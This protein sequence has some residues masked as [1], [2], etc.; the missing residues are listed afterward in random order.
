MLPKQDIQ[1]KKI[2]LRDYAQAVLRRK[3]IVIVSF[4]TLVTTVTIFSFKATPIYQATTQVMINKENP[5]VVSFKEVMSLDIDS[6]D[7]MFYQT[8]YKILASR[9]LALRVINSLNLKD[10]LEFKPDEKSKGFS[11]RGFVG[12]LF[13]KDSQDS[14]KDEKKFRL[15]ENSGLIN[16]YLGKLTIAPIRNSRLANI[17]FKGAY[18]D[19]ITSIVNRHADEY[20]TRNLEM[21]FAASEDAAKWL[22]NQLYEK[23][24]MVEKAENALQLYKEKVG[25][26]SL[27]G[28]QNIIVQKL[29]ESNIALTVTRTKRIGLE[30]LYN[31]SKEYSEKPGMIES[32]PGVM[33]NLLIQRLKQQYILLSTDIMELSSKYGKNHPVMI[34]NTSKAKDLKNRIDAE[35]H[36]VIKGI[37]ASYRIALSKEEALAENLEEQKKDALKLNRKAIVY[38]TL[39]RESDSERAMY[40]ILLKRLKE[41]DITGAL[42]T[43][44]ISVIDL[45]TVPRYPI[46]PNKKLN[47]ILGAIVGLFL[48]IGMV[49]FLEYLDNTIKSPEDVEE[50]LK[51][52]LL[53]VLSHVKIQFGGESAPSEL[54]AHEMPRSVFAEAVRSIR[55]SVMFSV[56]DTSRKLIMITSAIQG[57]G[58]TFV[59]SNLATAIAQAGKNTLLVDADF[60][61]PR[62]NK[63]FSVEKNPGLCNHLIGEIEL[64]SIIKSTQIPNLSIVTCGNIP[65][66]PSEIM[67]SAVMKK[68]C[69][70]VRKRF[71]MVIFDT[72]PAMTVTDAI[73]LSTIVDGVIL[74]IKSGTTVKDT[75]KRCI[76]QIH[77]DKGEMLGAIVNEVDISKGGYYY[78]YYA[79]YY[80]YGYS[81]EKEWEEVEG[82]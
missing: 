68:F 49:F 42:Q 71:D 21:R 27:E 1:E 80:K 77:N 12:S 44:N 51:I 10:S 79:H 35:V 2:H 31:L 25:I 56:I 14:D 69:N 7:L 60:R 81:S 16:S 17:S 70:T 64:E 58:K 59:A 23:K 46:E 38:G 33:E 11:I 72:P 3:W 6:R 19:I 78:H 24:E 66:N 55:T 26:L 39:K 43:S 30:K 41:T 52:P 75:I 18:P 4:V 34:R 20:I 8:Q 47:I 28:R 53:G 36:K 76:S 74:T 50:Y 48:G 63:V 40:Q 9:S 32:I 65:P 15:K 13:R 22:Q 67:Q 73:V 29:E 57:E 37:E 82:A 54:I 61:K 5:N 62:I 45:A